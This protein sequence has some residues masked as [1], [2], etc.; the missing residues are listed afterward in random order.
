MSSDN[1]VANWYTLK[2]S[3]DIS[4]LKENIWTRV[5]FV[6]GGRNSQTTG[7]PNIAAITTLQLRVNDNGTPVTVNADCWTSFP[8]PSQ[9]VVS[10][11]FDDGR[12]SQQTLA[13]L[14]MDKYTIR[15]TMYVNPATVGNSTHVSLANLTNMQQ[16]GWS[17]SSHTYSHPDLTLLTDDQLHDEFFRSKKWLIDNGFAKGANELA[18]PFGRYNDNVLAIAKQYYRSV[19]RIIHQV[20]TVQ[21][22][23]RY[24]LRNFYML[25]TTT[26]A[27]AKAGIDSALANKEW[28][29]FTFHDIINGTLT[30]PSHWGYSDF[31]ALMLYL[32]QQNIQVRTIDEVLNN[33][34]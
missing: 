17:I 5:S 20:E 6:V 30:D 24:K 19:R 2:P 4:V 10:I 11:T 18:L 14:E 16:L 21:P 3:D 27:Q 31:A 32:S 29:I 12:L 28:A 33:T 8:A 26:L 34:W 15:G 7:S 9:G 25:D 13:K 23:D 22:G 1:L